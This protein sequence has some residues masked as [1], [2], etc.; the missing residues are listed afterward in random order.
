MFSKILIANRGEI[1]VRIIRACKELGVNTVA[2]YSTC[3]KESLHVKMADEAVCIGGPSAVD[4]YLNIPTI[5][6]AA[7]VKDVEAI[8]P[9]YGFL[10]ESAHFA[11]VCQSCNIKFVGPSPDNMSLMGDKIKAKDT[12]KKAGVPIVP[13]SDKVIENKDDA[14]KTAKEIGYPVIIK[15]AAGGGGKGMRICHNDVRLV[16]AFVT[17]Q[18]EAES[19][20]GNPG[21]YMEK[22][23]ENPRHI[24]VQ[25][26][27]DERGNVV[28]LGERDC[29]VQRNYQKLIEESPSPVL[30]KKL[31]KRVGE[32][33][34]K[35]VNNVGYQNAG[36]VEF[37]L[38][39]E[40]KFYFMEMNTRIQVEHPVSEIITGVDLIKH[41][42]AVASGEELSLKQNQIEF[43]G[44][45]IE[46]RINAE[47]PDKNFS[48][49]PGKI[50]KLVFP[51]GPGIRLDSAVYQ[52]YTIP[53]FYD[54][55]MAKLIS[56]GKRRKEA[57]DTMQRALGE[58][59]IEPLKNTIS[60]HKRILS[61]SNFLNGNYSTRFLDNFLSQEKS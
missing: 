21:I 61:H 49:S 44:H 18:S 5:I 32:Y 47:D 28:H 12:M 4:S 37:L 2:V 48:P 31:R 9:G 3:D 15:A 54:S 41:Q 10:A 7:D 23:L 8:H 1:A 20:F 19:A 24:E 22:Y 59:D 34:I 14:L 16:S 39:S 30:D 29:T 36:T 26:L 35:G 17:A 56:Y 38:D 27:A 33:A 6:S 52:G 43:D 11:E 55:L 53:P 51:G 57:I 46:C 13:G 50:E 25:V 42:L 60:L 58:F 45:V 40:G